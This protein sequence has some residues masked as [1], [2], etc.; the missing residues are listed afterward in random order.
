MSK[1]IKLISNKEKEIALE[2]EVMSKVTSGQITMKPKWYFILGSVFS[3]A[4]LVSLSVASVFFINIA[5]F[6][7]RKHGP[8]GQWRLEAM[9]NSFPI[10]IP[11]LAVLGIVLGIWLL[12]KYDFSYKKNFLFIIFGFILSIFI[13]GL[14]IDRLGVNDVWSKRG[15]MKKFYQGI[16]NQ[17]I[18]IQDNYGKGSMRNGRGNGYYWNK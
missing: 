3:I 10:W 18:L 8:M 17:E 7:L 15:V 5:M 12:K 11:I 9:L 13:A 6:L 2:K 4:G 1:K 14:V 16:E